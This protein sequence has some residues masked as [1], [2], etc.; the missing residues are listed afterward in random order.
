[1]N[2]KQLIIFCDF[3]GSFTDRDIGHRLYRTFAGDIILEPVGKWKKGLISSRQCLLEEAALV[4]VTE[5]QLYR[6][7]DDFALRDGAAE[8]YENIKR[9]DIPFY[10][11]S[12]GADLY[13]DYVLNKFGLTDIKV[14]ANH[15]YIDGDRFIL[16]F[17]YDNDGCERC[18][19][20]K[21]SRIRETVGQ[22]RERY[23]VVYIGDGLSDI[24][25][26]P[27]ADIL[28]AR[29]DLL[30]YCRENGFDAIEYESFFDIF[31]YLKKTG[32]IS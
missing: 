23:T 21:G 2:E 17:P 16:E 20:C 15:A 25:A 1:M 5:P 6:F 7:L 10:I 12:D 14:Y 28:F 11:T 29:G 27:E 8:F 9:R 4:R 13:I 31:E 18:G 32:L 26:A 3:D 19:S 22:E 24:C 30:G